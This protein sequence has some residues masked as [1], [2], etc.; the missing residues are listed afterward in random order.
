M[1]SSQRLAQLKQLFKEDGIELSDGAALEIGI[2]L[3][4]RV[5]SIKLNIPPEKEASLRKIIEEMMLFRSL[6]KSKKVRN[7]AMEK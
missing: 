2:W 5:K 1:I 7:H 4:E 3:I 6:Y